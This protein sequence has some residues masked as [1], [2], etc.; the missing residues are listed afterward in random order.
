MAITTQTRPAPLSDAQREVLAAAAQRPEGAVILPARF[1]GKAATKIVEA[2]IG[3]ALV[4]EI[5]AKGELPVWRTDE[6]GKR[7][8]LVLT[9]TG[10]ALVPAAVA[11]EP[12]DTAGRATSSAQSD[13]APAQ[14]TGEPT[15]APRATSKL[16]A[17]IALLSR[18]TGSSVAELMATT[19]W[20]PHTT[21]AALT[22]LRKR[23]YPVT[24]QAAEDGSVYRIATNPVAAAA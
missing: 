7:Y 6:S 24:R 17:V 11:M 23:G 21:R 22:G 16:A 19:G 1:R 3:K 20:L 15:D 5:R 9:K 14:A 8:G 18:D 2:L 4:R 10:R 13:A 12:A